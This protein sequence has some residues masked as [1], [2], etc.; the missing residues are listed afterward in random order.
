MKYNKII[1]LFLV[2]ALLISHSYAMSMPINLFE[3]DAHDPENY[4]IHHEDDEHG[5]EDENHHDENHHDENHHDENHH[6]ENHHDEDHIID[7]EPTLLTGVPEE[8]DNGI[9]EFDMHHLFYE[10]HEF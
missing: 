9:L 3:D 8:H 5:H 7:H 10:F 1:P 6:D 4:T 2:G